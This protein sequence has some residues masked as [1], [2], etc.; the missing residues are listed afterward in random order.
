MSET[1]SLTGDERTDDTAPVGA[2]V[3]LLWTTSLA[4]LL[5]PFALLLGAMAPMATDSCGPDDCGRA[6]ETTL[7]IVIACWFASWTLTPVLVVASW[8]FPSRPWYA[9][10]RRYSGR[11]ALVPPVIVLL[12]VFT[13]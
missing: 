7:D 11:L 8:L 13:L 5:V 1:P 2:G 9:R 3:A 10:V 6:M 4:V 12:L